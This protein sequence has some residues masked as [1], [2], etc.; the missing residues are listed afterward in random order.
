MMHERHM[1]GEMAEVVGA[2]P[3][4]STGQPIDIPTVLATAR[5]T[6]HAWH[7]REEAILLLFGLRA[8]ML[9]QCK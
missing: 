6:G 3:E 7:G 8:C 1:I 9:S 2:D 5:E 4:D